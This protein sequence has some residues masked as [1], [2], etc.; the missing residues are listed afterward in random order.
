MFCLIRDGESKAAVVADEDGVLAFLDNRPLFD[1]H[2]L[3]I[4]REH[5]ATL[6]DLPPEK[7]QPIFSL[8]QRLSVAVKEAM[9]ADGVF[10][11]SNN[12]V[13]QSVDHLHVHVVPRKRKDGLRGF[14]WPRHRYIN[15]AEAEEIAARIRKFL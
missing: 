10:I 2:V 12:G 8:T 7:V 14:M 5:H 4:P 11:A 13:S 9:E 6:M 15:D 1:G 3:V